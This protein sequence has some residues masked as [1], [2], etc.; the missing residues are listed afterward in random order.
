M[1]VN[2]VSFIAATSGLYSLT[3]SINSPA[4]L[5]RYLL[6]INDIEIQIDIT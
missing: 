1:L 3:K 5:F 2:H 6:C 4:L